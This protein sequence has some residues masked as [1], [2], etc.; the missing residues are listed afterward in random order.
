M[1]TILGMV[2][3][4]IDEIYRIDDVI[5]D[6]SGMIRIDEN[7]FRNGVGMFWDTFYK[8]HRLAALLA[9][10]L[11]IADLPNLIEDVKNIFNCDQTRCYILGK[12][13][14][15]QY[16]QEREIIDDPMQTR[17]CKTYFECIL[18]SI[19]L[20]SDDSDHPEKNTG[21]RMNLDVTLNITNESSISPEETSN[22]NKNY[23]QQGNKALIID[24]YPIKVKQANPRVHLKNQLTFK[25]R[26]C[27]RMLEFC[28][29][30]TKQFESKIV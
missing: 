19:K 25:M 2:W 10:T 6:R 27:F 8:F 13:M 16:A 20:A 21:I 15:W 5:P 18:E 30:N 11:L 17:I 14:C 29:T 7:N 4:R 3:I 28:P 26:K 1:K 24:P 9:L 23:G 22:K 12:N